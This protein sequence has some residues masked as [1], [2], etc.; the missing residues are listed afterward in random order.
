M[1]GVL[2]IDL[3]IAV[4]FLFY[5]FRAA[6]TFANS[7]VKIVEASISR[8]S[9]LSVG[10]LSALS[11]S[12]SDSVFSSPVYYDYTTVDSDTYSIS[13]GGGSVDVTVYGGEDNYNCAVSIP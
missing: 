3:I 13:V 8:P 7:G 6:D 12:A 11:Y 1:R 10:T 5:M 4:L 2:S 9:C